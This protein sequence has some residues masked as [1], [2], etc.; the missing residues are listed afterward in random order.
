V[1]LLL[2][3]ARRRAKRNTGHAEI[4]VTESLGHGRLSIPAR[5]AAAYLPRPL[6]IRGSGAAA[7]DVTE[8]YGAGRLVFI[9]NELLARLLLSAA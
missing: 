3:L 2:L 7:I 6:I 5:I 8:A 9:D 4:L 1:S